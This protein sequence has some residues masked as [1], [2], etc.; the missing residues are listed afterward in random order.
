MHTESKN[1]KGQSTDFTQS[2]LT[3]KKNN[4]DDVIRVFLLLLLDALWEM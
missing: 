3:S 1:L 2:V 4:H